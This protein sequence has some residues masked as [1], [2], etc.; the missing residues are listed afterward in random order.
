VTA[1]GGSSAFVSGIAVA[2][3]SDSGPTTYDLFTLTLTSSSLSNL[4][5]Y[6]LAGNTDQDNPYNTA[7]GV[8]SDG[9]ATVTASFTEPDLGSTTPQA[10][11]V[12]F[13]I[14][15][16]TVGDTFDFYATTP[17]EGNGY[18]AYIG[19]VTVGTVAAP[20]PGTLGLMGAGLTGLWLRRR[21]RPRA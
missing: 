20:E 7:I 9:G 4:T 18:D 13:S 12:A 14:T 8:S 15:G 11:F 17:G 19:G 21:R 3:A 2:G 1:P 6:V 10:D 16:A 5:F